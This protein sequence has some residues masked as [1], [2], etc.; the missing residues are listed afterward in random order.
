MCY[1]HYDIA[2]LYNVQLFKRGLVLEEIISSLGIRKS[3]HNGYA[4]RLNDTS[5]TIFAYRKLRSGNANDTLSVP[6]VSG[7]DVPQGK[8]LELAE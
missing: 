1:L 8:L 7:R 4:N 6:E 5:H 3:P 2:S